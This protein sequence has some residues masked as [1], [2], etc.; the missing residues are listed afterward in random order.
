MSDIAL[1]SYFLLVPILMAALGGFSLL[2]VRGNS[3]G[4]AI[5]AEAIVILTSLCVWALI[6]Y[7][8][9]DGVTLFQFAHLLTITLSLDG[10]GSVFAG[11]I[12]ILWPLATLYSFEYM[13][14]EPRKAG[15]FCCY[16]VTYAVTL[17]IA[18]AGNMLTLYMFYELLTLITVPLV[19]HP[20]TREAIRASRKYLYYSLGGAAF[21]FIGLVF[22]IVNG[23]TITFLPGGLI[24]AYTL[25]HEQDMMLIIYVLTF[26][27]FS[28]KA[29]MFPFHGWLPSASVAP[30]PV[31]A[32]LHAVAVVKA[33]AFAIIRL[34]YFS[35]GTVFLKNTWAQYLVMTVAMITIIYASA[36][37]LRE[38]HFKRRLA[39]STVSNLS[40]IL[41]AASMMS[42]LG[43][44]AALTHMVCHAL[45]KISAF[46]CAGAVMH[47]TERTYIYELDGLGR[48]MP[49]VFGCF[50]ISSLSLM[51]VP[52][53]ACF[54]SKWK[55][56]QAAI[57]TSAFLP[58][59]A[60]AVLLLSALLTAIYM[61][62][63]VFRA[64]APIPDGQDWK[65]V[66]DPNWLMLVPLVLFS[67]GIIAI[68]VYPA[69]LLSILEKIALWQW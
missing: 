26:F 57:S 44:V 9:T 3:R 29:A 5:Y 39:Y 67:V 40:Y 36:T 35:Y 6:L 11:L 34:T 25:S 33:G 51:G 17:G 69:P 49:I 50:T 2:F 53:F 46:F 63:I 27:G 20:M 56:G 24:N 22:L 55:I 41:L 8:P 4:R 64:F 59:I 30:T 47:Q 14:H 31:T 61:L 66:H 23:A 15:F 48:K 1:P 54:I 60:V 45:T 18:F 19:I 68:G 13:R 43:M 28:V 42:P 38:T 62:T 32:L 10:C 7:R 52:L 21:A 16:I 12:A 37:A 58:K 65:D